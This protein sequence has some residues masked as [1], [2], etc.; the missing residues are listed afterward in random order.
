MK[1]L[2]LRFAKNLK[3]LKMLLIICLFLRKIT[4]FLRVKI[5]KKNT[6][7]NLKIKISVKSNRKSQRSIVQQ[8][9]LDLKKNTKFF[10]FT[11]YYEISKIDRES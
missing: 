3:S 11:T 6:E 9:E 10:H 1:A 4:T 5:K 2:V 7:S 8:N